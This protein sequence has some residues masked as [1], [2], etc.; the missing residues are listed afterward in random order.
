M[1][2][3]HIQWGNSCKNICIFDSIDTPSHTVRE[4]IV[5]S[6]R[7]KT[8]RY[9]L[10]YSEG[11]TTTRTRNDFFS[12]HPHI[13]WGNYWW[14]LLIPD[15]AD[16]P[17]HTVRE[18]GTLRDQVY[19]R[20]YTLTYSEGTV[21][22][23]SLLCSIA[24]HPHIQWGNRATRSPYGLN[25]DTPSHTVR[26]QQARQRK[27]RRLRYTLTYSEGTNKSNK[28]RNR[29]AIHP[30]IQW[31]NV[32]FSFLKFNLFDTPSHTVREPA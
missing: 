7:R 8:R 17:S 16:T 31:G 9:T 3:P 23:V 13:Q 24:I 29:T 14:L 5:I 2:H 20:R 6:V 11:T 1:I 18:R 22:A 30:H 21:R 32:L 12:I 4:P 19:N 15:N 26:E 28:S 27:E 25:L 10:T